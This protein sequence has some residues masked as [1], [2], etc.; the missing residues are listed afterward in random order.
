MKYLAVTFFAVFALAGTATAAKL[1]T[2]KD[3]KD[4]TIQQRDLK[5]GLLLQ[6][7][8]GLPG[9]PGPAGSPGTPGGPAGPKGDKGDPGAQGPAGPFPEGNLPAGKTIRGNWAMATED[10]SL[11]MTGFS[12]GFQLVASPTVHIIQAAAATPA[13]CTGSVTNPG[14]DSGHLCVFETGS[15]NK[16]AGYPSFLASTRWGASIYFF[17]AGAGIAYD[18]GT[19]AVTS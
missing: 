14:A 6:G 8:R 7:P 13:G 16:A 11:G 2:S 5:R 9:A 19:W 18:Y 1:I 10:S 12:F 3:I 15:S 17:A 4:H